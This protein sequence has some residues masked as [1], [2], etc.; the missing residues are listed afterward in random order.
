MNNPLMT[1]KDVNNHEN[2]IFIEAARQILGGPLTVKKF[3]SVAVTYLGII[4]VREL[5]QANQYRRRPSTSSTADL[6]IRLKKEKDLLT[7]LL[8]SATNSVEFG[9][10]QQTMYLPLVDFTS[11]EEFQSFMLTYVSGVVND[12]IESGSTAQAEKFLTFTVSQISE[13]LRVVRDF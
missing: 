3:A 4:G 7:D 13:A 1:P 10:I 11:S 5:I 2:D 6:C 12:L 9:A 8:G